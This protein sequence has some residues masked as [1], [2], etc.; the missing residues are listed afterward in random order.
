VYLAHEKRRVKDRFR[1]FERAVSFGKELPDGTM[2]DKNYVWFSEW[3]LQNINANHLLP[4]DLE[5]YRELKNHIAKA[6]VPLLQVWLYATRDEGVFE[7]R[8][9]ELCQILNIQ[10]YR[11]LSLIK[12][13]LGPSLDELREFGYLEDWNVEETSDGDSYKIIFHHGEKF[14]RDRR[15]R[16][17]R[18]QTRPSGEPRPAAPSRQPRL[19]SQ[20]RKPARVALPLN[21]EWVAELVNRG[22][23]ETR[24]RK[25]L[26]NVSAD[27]PV[28]DE[29]EWGDLQIEQL[30][31]RITN[32]AGFY[33]SLVTEKV[34]PPPTFETKAKRIAREEG[35]RRREEERRARED[36]ETEY[37]WYCEE[38]I[39]R[40]VSG[41]D[42]AEYTSVLEAKRQE[43]REKHQSLSPEI[44]EQFAQHE[45]KREL[46]KRAPLM[47]MEE[48]ESRRAETANSLLKP[49]A[50]PQ[51]L[52][53]FEVE[54]LPPVMQD[55]AI[56]VDGPPSSPAQNEGERAAPE[57]A[58]TTD[59]HPAIAEPMIDPAFPPPPQG[60]GNDSLGPRLF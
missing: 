22:V 17:R 47:T 4:I 26:A 38:E 52:E 21:E 31:G 51:I 29:L 56:A 44:I 2:A 34:I 3:Q 20:D 1:V 11:Y 15:A 49:V 25:I 16:L 54:A 36:L 33:I 13:T 59:A 57:P 5:A 50:E 42:A 40:Y 48:F 45:A 10:H 30:G 37:Q 35:E 43:N 24:A 46:G 6:L 58:S 39:D 32:P 53:P 60:A 28:M 8:Y 9:D 18:K 7:K 41:L 14:H 19:A 23:T 27:Q 12:R 55:A